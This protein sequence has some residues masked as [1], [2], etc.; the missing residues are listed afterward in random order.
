MRRTGED[1]RARV[2]EAARAEFARYGLNGARIDRI[3]K[4]A[5]AS[6]ERLYAYFDSKE[7]LFNE[8]IREGTEGGTSSIP[9]DDDDL[10]SYS[11]RLYEHFVE[12]PDQV[13]M[14][15]WMQLEEQCTT[16]HVES[17]IRLEQAK[18]KAVRRAQAAGQVD[19]QWNPRELLQ[20]IHSV[21]TFWAVTP[22]AR[23]K[24]T[25]D[26]KSDVEETVRR[27]INPNC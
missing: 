6:K 4:S 24:T 22:A 19:A 1:A 9:I 13:R 11:G 20:L 10:V 14:L 27:L 3:A 17:V 5:G 16:A 18:G 8:A 12:Y 2:L 23:G 15:S 25:R 26:R 21:A 7:T